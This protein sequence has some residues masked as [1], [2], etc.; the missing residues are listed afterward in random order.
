MIRP[1]PE[2]LDDVLTACDAI[3]RHLTKLP[4]EEDL[5]FDAIR[6][7]LVEIGEAV[8]DLDPALL[9][10]ETSIPWTEIARMR[11]LLTHRY[12]DTVHAIVFTTA[13]TDIPLLR[14]A[15]GRILAN[16]DR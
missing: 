14:A 10:N 2:R 12:F 7:R 1:A 3:A 8:K 11:D 16:L 13:R 5:V 15:I 4:A 9:S 6:I